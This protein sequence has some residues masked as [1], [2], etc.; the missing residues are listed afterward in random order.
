MG[1]RAGRRNN[2]EWNIAIRLSFA[3]PATRGGRADDDQAAETAARLPAQ[4]HRRARVRAD[5][6][7]DRAPLPA[8]VAGHRA[9]A[10]AQPA[11]EAADQAPPA[12]EPRARG[13]RARHRQPGG[14][15]A[16][17]RPGGGGRADRGGRDRGDHHAPRGDARPRR[18]V[19]APRA[20]RLD[21]RR[22]HPRRR[23]RGGRVVPGRAERRDGGSARAWRRNRQEAPARARAGAPRAGQRA[24]RA[25]RRACERRRDPRRRDR[26]PPP[27]PVTTR[28]PFALYVHVPYCRHVCPYCDFNV[29]AAREPP[30]NDYI[31]ALVAEAAFHA[32]TGDFSGRAVQTVYIGGGTPS[33]FSPAA[34]G[35]LL[36]AIARRFAL[37][38]GAEVTLEANPGTVDVAR[39]TGYRAARVNRLSTGAQSFAPQHRLLDRLRL[40]R[41]RRRRPLLQPDPVSRPPLDEREDTSP[42]HGHGPRSSDR[43]RR[44]PDRAP[45]TRRILLLRPPPYRRDQHRRVPPPLRHRADRRVPPRGASNRR[46]PNRAG[47]RPPAP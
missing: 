16:A 43:Q 30:E 19:R 20:R 15:R 7:G 42:L 18:D 28:E 29:Q 40:P 2:C 6:R 45:G 41:P 11:A 35:T 23:P 4:L 22:G 5:A 36:D 21:G 38:P 32:A 17:P 13:D 24:A 44:P 12:S 26:R 14:Y 3:Y 1:V 9:Q 34:I 10:P 33:L 37:L 46:R 8:R 47:S 39:L 25:D 31:K 27:L